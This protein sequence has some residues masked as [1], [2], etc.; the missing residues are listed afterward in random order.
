[1]VSIGERVKHQ[2]WFGTMTWVVSITRLYIVLTL[3]EREDMKILEVFAKHIKP[4]Y[5]NWTH[6]YLMF[7]WKLWRRVS[8]VLGR[9]KET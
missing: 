9:D 1:M 6:T 7:K 4:H 3:E 8:D 2:P 5:K